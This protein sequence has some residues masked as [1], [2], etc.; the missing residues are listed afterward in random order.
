MSGLTYLLWSN[1]HSAWWRADAR[2]YTYEQD[3]AGRYSEA[4]AIRYVVQSA[5]GGDLAKVTCMVAAPHSW[6]PEDGDD[7]T[8]FSGTV[9][10]IPGLP[11]PVP[12]A[13]CGHPAEQLK[14]EQSDGSVML[15]VLDGPC[16]QCWL[17]EDD[18]YQRGQD[19]P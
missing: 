2:G 7:L 10:T 8:E 19:R 3:Q 5:Q 15:A 11:G 12:R 4:E 13:S 17:D 14:L 9:L 18:A 6:V 16:S 1:K